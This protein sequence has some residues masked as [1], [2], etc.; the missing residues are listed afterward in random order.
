VTTVPEGE[1][2]S[3]LSPNTAEFSI[4]GC[5][6]RVEIAA[7]KAISSRDGE[8]CRDLVKTGRFCAITEVEIPFLT[9]FE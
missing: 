9:A 3:K 1:I 8:K 5:P 4:I 2:S 7:S 6:T